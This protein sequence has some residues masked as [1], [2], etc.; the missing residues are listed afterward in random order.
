MWLVI[1]TIHIS[2]DSYLHPPS[3]KGG[4]EK[5]QKNAKGGPRTF[6]LN[7]GGAGG[8]FIF[9]WGT[10]GVGTIFR[11][12]VTPSACHVFFLVAKNKTM[13]PR[14]LARKAVA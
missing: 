4:H 14:Y 7:Q 11:W 5:L 3:N 10:G 1:R 8:F 2:H 12:G 6:W 13:A 9:S